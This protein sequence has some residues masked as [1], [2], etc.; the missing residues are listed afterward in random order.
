[1]SLMIVNMYTIYPL[2][3]V[4]QAFVLRRM[5]EHRLEVMNR[6]HDLVCPIC[7]K[8]NERTALARGIQADVG[9]RSKRMILGSGDNFY[10]THE[11]AKCVFSSIIPE[12]IEYFAIP[13]SA[14]YV[15]TARSRL[16]PKESDTGF[17]FVRRRCT[18][19]GRPGEVI[20]GKAALRV[21]EPKPFLA[22]NLEGVQGARETWIVSEEVAN[23]LRKVT[24]PLTG[25]VILPKEVD[26]TESD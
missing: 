12:Q 10:I 15:A 14:F 26:D 7:G 3:S 20:W 13:N 17:R 8:L 4:D 23:A 19:C 5:G 1:M 9:I 11:M 16:E 24:P 22:V 21:A 25:M 18:A 2:D 6:Y